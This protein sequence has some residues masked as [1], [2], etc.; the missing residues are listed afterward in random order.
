MYD[1]SEGDVMNI[2][3]VAA[4]ADDEVLGCGGTIAKYKDQGASVNVAILADGV[5][6]RSTEDISSNKDLKIRNDAARDAN[7]ILGVDEVLFGKFPD[8]RMDSVDLLDVVKYVEK[9]IHKFKPNLVLTHHSNDLNIDHRIVSQAVCT[10]CRPQNNYSVKS[11]Y[12]FEVPSSTE[13]Q[14]NS[15]N[16]FSPHLFEDITDYLAKKIKALEIYSMEMRDWPHSRSIEGV[17]HL[18]KW[19]GATVGVDSAE[20]FIVG[21]IVK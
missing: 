3:V 20:S 10:A 16:A 21:R 12:F 2:L 19:R 6:S 4:H 7:K 15:S 14:I 5:S 18:A 9:L 1:L 17:T 13:W 8:N 11:I